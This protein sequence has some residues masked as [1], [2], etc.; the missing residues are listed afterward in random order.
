MEEFEFLW[1]MQEVLLLKLFW[2]DIR[3]EIP[4]IDEQPLKHGGRKLESGIQNPQKR[5]T[6]RNRRKLHCIALHAKITIPSK[7]ELKLNLFCNKDSPSVEIRA[8]VIST[9]SGEGFGHLYDYEN[10][11]NQCVGI[12]S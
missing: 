11:N 1:F 8:T 10:L 7:K 4:T 12:W 2:K 6:S 3:T 9:C 5:T